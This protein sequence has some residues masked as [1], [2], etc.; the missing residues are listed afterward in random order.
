[1]HGHKKK[2]NEWDRKKKNSKRIETNFDENRKPEK[3][4]RVRFYENTEDIDE[5]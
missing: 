4:K 3:K 5:E 2:T 1:M